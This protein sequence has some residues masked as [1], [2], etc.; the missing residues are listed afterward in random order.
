M[1]RI[2]LATQPKEAGTMYQHDHSPADRVVSAWIEFGQAVGDSVR[3]VVAS[4]Q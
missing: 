2:G 1:T 3:K 4:R